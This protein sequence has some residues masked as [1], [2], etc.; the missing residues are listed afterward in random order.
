MKKRFVTL[1]NYKGIRKDTVTGKY[2]A[3]KTVN[4]KEYS[5][6]FEKISDAVNWR[7]N[8]HPLLTRTEISKGI[9]LNDYQRD[10]KSVVQVRQ[11]GVDQRFTFGQVWELYKRQYFPLLEPQT[12]DD[13][14][15]YAK[16]FFPDL[17]PLKMTEIT[18][19]LLDVFMEKQVAKAIETG[20]RKRK[21]FDNDLKTLKA[22]L[23]WYRENYDSMFVMPVLK[24]HKTMGIIRREPK[25]NSTKMTLE[26]VKLF[27]A[28]FDDDFWRDFAEIHFYMAGRS[29]EIAGLQWENINFQKGLIRV[30]DV[31]IWGEHKRFVRLK[32]IPKNGDER[33]VFI[34]KRMKEILLKRKENCSETLS[35]FV[36][37]STGERLNFVFENDGQPVS[38]RM[39]QY[40]YNKA[41]KKAGLYSKFKSTHI[42]RKAMANI[43]RQEMGLDAA[44]AAGGW[45]SRE[46]V[47][48]T[49]T[50][51]PNSL[52]KEAV[53]LVERMV[54][55]K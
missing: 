17:M 45:K 33:I 10:L 2:V 36:R 7:R 21:N 23:N 1:K 38:Y 25:R 27:F 42:L 29:Q 37:E 53:E 44:Q 49:Y 26:Q 20:H 19:E 6:T 9:S 16:N 14:L 3:R 24:R 15:K 52:N 54:V 28:S 11:N 12:V 41:L 5:E 51:A 30:C 48:K 31:V 13:R 43:V 39:I 47:E 4:R 50:D 22:F 18:S 32:E 46:V 34:N 40:Q 55:E 35:E 8:F